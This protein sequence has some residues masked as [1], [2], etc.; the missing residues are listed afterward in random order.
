MRGENGCLLKGEIGK[1]VI[2]FRK[3]ISYGKIDFFAGLAEKKKLFY[4]IFIIEGRKRLFIV[5]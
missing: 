4:R 3:K 1:Y 2:F 5:R